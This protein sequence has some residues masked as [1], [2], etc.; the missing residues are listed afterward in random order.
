M[1]SRFDL[2][3]KNGCFGQESQEREVLCHKRTGYFFPIPSDKQCQIFYSTCPLLVVLQG[4][5]AVVA[6]SCYYYFHRV[7]LCLLV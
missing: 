1:I 3:P 5:L 4:F 6:H 7:S 2:C